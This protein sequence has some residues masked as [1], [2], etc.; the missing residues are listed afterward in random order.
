MTETE[1]KSIFEA[2][3]RGEISRPELGRRI[4]EDLSFGDTVLRL[5]A[6][7]L[8]LPRLHGDPDA[9]GMVFVR[10]LLQQRRPNVR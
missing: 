3:S 1:V 4:G 8:T 2:Y 7:R 5:H 10:K 9:A 6:Y